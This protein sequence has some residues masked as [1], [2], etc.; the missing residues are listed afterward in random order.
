MPSMISSIAFCAGLALAWCTADAQDVIGISRPLNVPDPVG[1][2]RPEDALK[3]EID[4]LKERVTRIEQT[5]DDD[6]KLLRALLS[7]LPECHGEPPDHL[8]CIERD[9]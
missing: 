5:M 2:S 8:P 1:I 9:Q 7:Y 3:V 6:H 4:D